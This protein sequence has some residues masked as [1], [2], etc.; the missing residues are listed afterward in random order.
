VS[1][2]RA[3][4][5]FMPDRVIKRYH[6]PSM[7]SPELDWYL[8]VGGKF[9]PR[10]LDYDLQRGDLIIERG[11]AVPSPRPFELAN[12]IFSLQAE[13]IHHRDVHPG[14]LVLVR[15]RL[16]LIDW[17][18]AIQDYGLRLSYDLFGPVPSGVPVPEAHRA[19]RS[20]RSPNGYQMHWGADHPES[21][22][23]Q[24]GVD[25]PVNLGEWS[26]SGQG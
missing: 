12:L 8:E 3:T 18:H 22:K 13:G 14:N 21:I 24:W 16:R 2:A 26:R 25:V 20:K 7:I 4:K 10:L 1:D 17:E 5:V 11:I 6:D 19:I 15:D 23:N 9:A